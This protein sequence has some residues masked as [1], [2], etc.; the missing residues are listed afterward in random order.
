MHPTIR[1]GTVAAFA[2]GD[3]LCPDASEVLRHAG[4]E[5][6]VQGRVLYFSDGGT[7]RDQFAIV[8]VEGIHTPVIVPVTNLRLEGMPA[9]P[10]AVELRAA[11]GATATGAAANGAP[12]N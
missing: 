9:Y 12:A 2:I 3:V 7:S 6:T 11:A 10:A 1:A 8:E 5:L 4:P